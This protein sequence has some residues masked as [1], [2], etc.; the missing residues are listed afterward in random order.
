MNVT[1]SLLANPSNCCKKIKFYFNLFKLKTLNSLLAS[2]SI[3]DMNLITVKD[4]YLENFWS[5]WV[6]TSCIVNKRRKSKTSPF[7]Y[8]NKTFPLQNSMCESISISIVRLLV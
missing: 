6:T 4:V 3:S 7:L 1:I 5:S 8:E 2:I